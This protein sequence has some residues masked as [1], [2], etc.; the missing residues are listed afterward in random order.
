MRPAKKPVKKPLESRLDRAVSVLSR[1]AEKAR[2]AVK[3][4]GRKIAGKGMAV[5]AAAITEAIERKKMVKFLKKLELFSEGKFAVTPEIQ[6]I[7]RL[8]LRSGLKPKE[9]AG[10]L[11]VP[12]KRNYLVRAAGQENFREIARILSFEKKE[13]KGVA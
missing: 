2:G 8:G 3:A 7:A 5:L 6:Q 10:I 4:A 1:G 11:V 9:L 12:S 13:L